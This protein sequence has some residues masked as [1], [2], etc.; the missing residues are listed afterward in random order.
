MLFNSWV[1]ILLLI[2][3]FFIYYLPRFEKLQVGILIISSLVFYA[4]GQPGLLLL[5]L[6]SAT[7]NIMMSYMTVYGAVNRRKLYVTLGVIINLALL[8]YFKYGSLFANTFMDTSKGLG[9]YLTMIPLPIGISFYTFEGISLLIDV[10]SNRHSDVLTIDKS[11]KKHVTKTLFFISFFPHLIAGPILKAYEFY[12]QIGEKSIKTIDWEYV[13]RKL[14][15]GYFL[16]MVV[17]DN[18]SNVTFWMT[19]P[20]FQ[21]KSSITLIGMLLGYSF[22]IFADFAGYSMIALGLAKMFGYDLLENFNFPYISTSFSEFWRRWHISLSTFLK[23]YL[24]IP[25][26]GNRKGHFRTYFNLTITMV[27]GGLWHGAAWSYAV[28]GAFHGLA[29]AIERLINQTFH[30]EIDSRIGKILKGCMVFAFVT[31]AWLLFR[32]PFN[33]VVDY[34]KAIGTNTHVHNDYLLLFSIVIYSMPVV[35]YHLFYL[36]PVEWRLYNITNRYK[37]LAY[38]LMLFMIAVNSGPSGSFI[39]F[40]F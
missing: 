21:T 36:L 2:V 17:A 25:L 4:Y 33:D 31:L 7:I 12:P 26:G 8:S 23:E 9:H 22:Q 15:V 34:L 37:Y 5:L 20:Y 40:Q 27:L 11:I 10:Y 13:F 30:I 38:G 19:A 24:Y 1:F 28:W 3:T 35:L 29:L 14:T 39:Y 6:C 18:L 32:L 16:K